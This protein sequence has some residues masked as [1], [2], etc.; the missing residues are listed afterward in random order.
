MSFLLILVV[1]TTSPALADIQPP[2]WVDYTGAG[3]VTPWE[4]SQQTLSMPFSFDF[5]GGDRTTSSVIVQA[6]G[7]LGFGP[8]LSNDNNPPAWPYYT[9]DERYSRIA[10][11]MW[12]DLNPAGGSNGRVYYQTVGGGA[13]R[14]FVVT[15]DTYADPAETQHN[16]FQIQLHEAT[17]DISYHYH[18]LDGV[19]DGSRVG[20]NYG[21]GAEYT[22]FWYD[23]DQNY[24]GGGGHTANQDG[25]NGSLEG[26]TINYTFNEETGSYDATNNY[27]PEPGTLALLLIGIAGGIAARRRR[28]AETASISD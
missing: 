19:E 15:W 24:D 13:N 7:Y 1:A 9:W 17:G 11:P 2:G 10:A 16:V 26:W 20:I 27:V 21:D 25:P 3:Y 12:H 6:N 28:A 23:G 18:S 22:G 4:N 8:F 14:R 5:Y